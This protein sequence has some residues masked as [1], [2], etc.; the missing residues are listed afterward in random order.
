VET[1]NA[2][3][4][5][6]ATSSELAIASKAAPFAPPTTAS[7]RFTRWRKLRVEERIIPRNALGPQTYR[8]VLDT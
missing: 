5:E 6:M 3:V 4:G 2:G 8:I 7:E 1:A